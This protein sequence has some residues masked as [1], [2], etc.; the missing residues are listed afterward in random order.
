VYELVGVRV[1]R[2]VEEGEVVVVEARSTAP[3]AVCPGCVQASARVHSRYVRTLRDLSACGR[4]VVV[5]LTVRRFMC[6]AGACSRRTFVEQVAGA[7]VRYRRATVRLE[8]VVRAIGVALGGEAGSR[9]AGTI[10]AA[11]GGDALLRL[12]RR[13]HGALPTPRVLGVDDWAWRRGRRYGS[14]LVDLEARRPIDLLEDRS[15]GT[16]AAWLQEHPGVEIIVRDRSPEYARGATMGAPAALQA[17]DRWHVLKHVRE[18]A[19]RLLDRHRQDL[20]QVKVDTEGTRPRRRAAAEEARRA[21]L[22]LR[23]AAFHAEVQRRAANGGTILGIARDLGVTR[24]MVRRY[25]FADAPPERE[26]AQRSSGLDPFAPYLRRRWAEGCRN[27]LLLWRE[28]REQGYAGTSRQVSRW[29]EDRRE[30]DAS[31]PTMG[32]PRTIPRTIPRPP[33]T[34]AVRRAARRPSVPQL[35]WLL[36]RDPRDLDDDDLAVLGRLQAAC[37]PAATAYPLLQEITHIIKEQAH[38]RLDRWLVAAAASGIPDLMTFT[39]GLRRERT[40]VLAALTL[41]WSTGPVE[42]HITRLKLIKRQGYG[43]AGLDTLK[44]R[45]LRAA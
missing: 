31:A 9:L 27:A 39:D 16:L 19:E 10:G 45:F 44:R 32:R 4:A 12:L 15:A 43:R 33:D 6:Q 26:Y 22:R 5:R 25:L 40:E 20:R 23:A 35:A 8:M 24:T 11:V 41:P 42:G 28:I 17:V 38:E 1:E 29:A 36:V 21:T 13:D 37:S 34:E 18:V 7:T 30:R 2:I 3:G 14:V